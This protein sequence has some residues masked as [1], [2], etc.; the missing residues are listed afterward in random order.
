[1]LLA[2]AI[3]GTR[4]QSFTWA[5]NM[6]GR[7][8]FNYGY[9]IAVDANGNS[10]TTGYYKGACDFD[11]GAGSYSLTSVG[12]DDIFVVKLNSAGNF[13]WARSMGGTLIEHG[14]SIALDSQQNVYLTGTFQGTVDFD[15]GAGTYTLASAGGDD[16]FIC[17]LD[18]AGNFK[19]ARR[20]GNANVDGAAA[21]AID[22]S[23]NVLVTG[24]FHQIVDFDPGVGTATLITKGFSDGFILK[25]DN[26]GAFVWVKQ[27]GGGSDDG[28]SAI[29]CDASGNVYTCGSYGAV[30][31]MDPGAGTYTVQAAGNNDIFISKLDASGNFVWGGS[32]GGSNIDACGAIVLDRQGNIYTTGS[33]WGSGDLDPGVGT[34]T[35]ADIGNGDIFVEKLNSSGNLVWVKVMG[36]T[37][38]EA[39]HGIAID[40]NGNVITAG[41]YQGKADLDPGAGTVTYT[42][43][44]GADIYVSCLDMN[45]DYV[46]SKVIGGG[47]DDGAAC[48]KLDANDFIYTTGNFG[49]VVDFD[50][51]SAV[52]N[53]TSNGADDI[54]ILKMGPATVGIKEASATLSLLQLYPNPCSGAVTVSSAS[55]SS[56]VLKVMNM[57]GQ[58]VMEVTDH[59]GGTVFID[60]STQPTGVYLLEA[61]QDN[62]I[63]RA[64]L[65]KTE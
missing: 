17:K 55:S 2:F 51:G 45:G 22:P 11:P 34:Y 42:P 62:R 61:I 12:G 46:S 21:L 47:V 56:C 32:M 26:T 10:Y 35:V 39:G 44:W 50:P 36:G 5:K 28:G 6:G 58:V 9:G 19:W 1:M 29:T 31:D 20:V 25:L 27:M 59:D 16:D 64:K 57:A 53:L 4:A 24:F 41:F 52:M 18:S 60:M 54:F 14:L 33:F 49:G 63:S 37:G 23:D 43:V 8:N 40:G 38:G 30:L 15:P 48:L 65:V 7:G 13:V 3:S